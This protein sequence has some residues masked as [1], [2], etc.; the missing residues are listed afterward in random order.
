MS[1]T[2]EHTVRSSTS[3]SGIT[4][5]I[6]IDLFSLNTDNEEYYVCKEGEYGKMIY[7]DGTKC[8]IGWWH[9]GCAGITRKPRGKWFCTYCT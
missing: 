5:D 6:D 7:C 2:Q 4:L 8:P 9:Y 1:V 3:C